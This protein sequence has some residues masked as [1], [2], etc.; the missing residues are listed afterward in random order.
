[1]LDARIRK[2]PMHVTVMN[3]Y[4]TEMDSIV[5]ITILVIFNPVMNFRFVLSMTKNLMASAVHALS[6]RTAG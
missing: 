3:P 5:I 1:M 6:K 4:F 2:D